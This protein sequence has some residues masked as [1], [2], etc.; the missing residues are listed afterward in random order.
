[1]TIYDVSQIMGV[2]RRTIMRWEKEGRIQKAQRDWRGWRY[3]TSEDLERV[4]H[5]HLK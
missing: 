5:Y 4:F 1:M 3:Y 2:T